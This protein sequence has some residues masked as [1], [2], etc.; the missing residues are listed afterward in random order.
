MGRAEECQ[1]WRNKETVKD[2]IRFPGEEEKCSKSRKGDRGMMGDKI[3]FK[4]AVP[5]WGTGWR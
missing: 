4:F 5:H 3:I 1:L 2:G